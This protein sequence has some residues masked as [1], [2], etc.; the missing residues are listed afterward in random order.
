MIAY[1]KLGIWYEDQKNKKY[2]TIERF[3]MHE[4]EGLYVGLH[5]AW[6]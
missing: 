5:V 2:W 3:W 6:K 1:V 4:S